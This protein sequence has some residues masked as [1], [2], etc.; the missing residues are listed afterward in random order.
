MRADLAELDLT[1]RV[2]TGPGAVLGVDA[3]GAGVA[4]VRNGLDPDDYLAAIVT[5]VAA[6]V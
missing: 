3:S 2:K 6:A 1:R 5:R 4:L